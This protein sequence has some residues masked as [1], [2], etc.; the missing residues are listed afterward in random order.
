L[1]VIWIFFEHSLLKLDIRV[2]SISGSSGS[3]DLGSIYGFCLHVLLVDLGLEEFVD[4]GFRI[5]EERI[6]FKD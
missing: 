4:L 2:M 6:W 1:Q 3:I 5:L